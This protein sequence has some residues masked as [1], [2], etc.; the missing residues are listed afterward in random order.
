MNS[1]FFISF[2]V[3]VAGS[4]TALSAFSIERALTLKSN[5][6]IYSQ[7]FCLSDLFAEPWIQGRC[8]SDKVTCCKGSLEGALEREVTREEARKWLSGLDLGGMNFVIQGESSVVKQTRRALKAD[9][10]ES[11]ALANVALKV[12]QKKEDVKIKDLRITYPI[13]VSLTEENDWDVELPE[14]LSGTLQLKIISLRNQNQTLGWVQAGVSLIGEAYVAK[15]ALGARQALA[16][17]DFELKRVDLLDLTKAGVEIFKK[18]QFPEGTRAKQSLQRGSV[19]TAA[20]LERV[21][22]V[23]LGEIVTIVLRSDNLRIS[24][25]GVIQNPAAAGDMVTVQ[26]KRYSRTFRGRLAEDKSVEVWL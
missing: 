3:L 19:L 7:N 12:E 14:N 21:P 20:A 11:K 17:S 13:Y 18:G 16:A 24:T 1:K 4:L 23:Q 8:V 9:E 25:K 15:K 22:I 26:L 5:V 2:L 10:V 6:E